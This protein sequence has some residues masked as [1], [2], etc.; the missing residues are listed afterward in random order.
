M[1]VNLFTCIQV[2]I[3]RKLPEFHPQWGTVYEQRKIK[4]KV[5]EIPNC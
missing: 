5:I 2:E 1:K 3:V 4:V